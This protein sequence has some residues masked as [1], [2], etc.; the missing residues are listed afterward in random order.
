MRLEVI[1]AVSSLLTRDSVE[2]DERLEYDLI[3]VLKLFGRFNLAAFSL[4]EPVIFSN[5]YLAA[6]YSDLRLTM[7]P[8][9]TI[10]ADVKDMIWKVNR[11]WVCRECKRYGATEFDWRTITDEHCRHLPL[12]E[13]RKVR[14]WEEKFNAVRSSYKSRE[15]CRII[16]CRMRKEYIRSLECEVCHQEPGFMRVREAVRRMAK[17]FEVKREAI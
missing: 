12:D 14:E 8:G 6:E 3:S 1:Q 16:G 7:P 15:L 13:Y 17:G 4:I 2:Q 9:D 5:P 10:M 11:L